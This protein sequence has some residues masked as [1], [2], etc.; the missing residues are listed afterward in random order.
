MDARLPDS[1]GHLHS[2]HPET[3]PADLPRAD[4]RRP[5]IL[6]PAG[7]REMMHAAIENGA[8][9]VYFGVQA[10][11]A[12]LRA[13]NFTAAELPDVMRWLHSRG[14]RGYLTIN[15]LVFDH[16]LPEAL[17]LLRAAS[18]AGVDA[19]LI[20]D[21]GLAFAAG[22]VAPRLEVHASTQMTLSCAE[23]VAGTEALGLSLQ[24][25]VVPRELSRREL[26]RFSSECS[27]ELETFVHGALCVAYSGQCLTSEALGGRSANRGEC[28]QACRLPYGLLVDGEERD[29]GDIRFLLSPLDLAA[30]DDLPEL[31]EM[32][33]ASFKIEGRLKTPEYVAA[34]VQAYRSAMKGTL[35]ALERRQLVSTFSRGFT[36]G[37]L[38]EVDHQ[39]V[40]EGSFSGKR[41]EPVGSVVSVGRSEAVIAV[42]AELRAG[43]GVFFDGGARSPGI[44]GTI[45][46]MQRGGRVIDGFTPS[47]S[48]DTEVRLTVSFFNTI[49]LRSVA[50][51]DRVFKTADP[52]LERGLR[53]SYSGTKIRHQRRVTARLRAHVG[54]P[55][56]LRYVDDDGLIGE[57]I[58]GAP[59]EAA[60]EWTPDREQLRALVGRL[61]QTPFVLGD[62]LFD[63][64][65]S[66]L[67]PPS[68]L[69]ELRR[70]AADHL[71]AARSA[72]GLSRP[73]SAATVGEIRRAARES[74]PAAADSSSAEVEIGVLCRSLAQVEA[75]VQAGVR[76]IFTDFEDPRL[77]REARRAIPGDRRFVPAT[78][79][80]I[81]PGEGPTVIQLLRCEPDALLIRNLAAWQVVR[82]REPQLPL[83]GDH[84]LNVANSITASLLISR[85]FSRLTPSYDL[86]GEQL[87]TLLSECDPAWMEVT[88]HQHVPMFHMEHCV[89]CRFLSDG[90]D[91]SNCG[92]P[93]E[94]HQVE[95]RDRMG[96]A[97]PVKADSGCRNTVYHAV[98][99]SGVEYV[100]QLLERGIRRFRIDLVNETAAETLNALKLYRRACSRDISPEKVWTELRATSRLGV[101]RGTLDHDNTRAHEPL[102]AIRPKKPA[103]ARSEAASRHR[104][105]QA[106][107]KR[108]R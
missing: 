95:L 106:V 84:S 34:T 70:R 11:N 69:N 89:F 17:D 93:C 53:A 40:V 77:N 52:V 107:E 4:I 98:A 85:G 102:Y 1:I 16:E 46:Q 78:L 65:G 37:Y 56:A 83:I 32:G 12:R 33:I 79:R 44:G 97:H 76:E 88:L 15:T 27:R 9:A 6:A 43:D 18:D 39:A 86:N 30:H 36:G 72:R 29:L 60:R 108:S 99:Q 81:K 101:T 24:R 25:I 100:P 38:H 45:V 94:H 90:N 66:P 7:N 31:V 20:Q 62:L 10:F 80:I 50:A 82:T 73:T 68:R 14:V 55:L 59:L 42:R 3:L 58:D 64:E 57:A 23:S 22:K 92:R 96:L 2:L 74:C 35:S 103:H 19:V 21:L 5:E 48:A 26:R 63:L 13:D 105:R 49:D 91:A 87:L 47:S 8:D 51:G 61:G 54:E 41:G 104:S 71:L 67:I 75:A 28:A